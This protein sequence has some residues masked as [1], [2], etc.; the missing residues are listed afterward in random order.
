MNRQPGDLL[1]A[2]GGRAARGGGSVLRAC[3]RSRARP[4]PGSRG[5]AG[6][7]DM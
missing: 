3:V 1:R 4:P 5:E 7:G 6:R 2:R